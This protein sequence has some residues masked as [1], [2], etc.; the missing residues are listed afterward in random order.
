[1]N[2]DYL[3]DGSGDP[4]PKV[5]RLERLLGRL[6]HNRPAPEFPAPPVRSPRTRALFFRLTLAA[7]AVLLIAVAWQVAHRTETVHLEGS[8]RSG[9]TDHRPAPGPERPSG[10]QK[11]AWEVASL[12]GAPQVGPDRI[13]GT[14]RLPVGEWLE[15]DGASRARI[16]VGTIGQVQVEPNTRVR[17]VET[18]LTEHR[19]SLA[20]GTLHATIWAPPRLFFV[21]TPSAVAVDLG[22]AYTLKVDETGAGLVRVSA[23]W[24]A[25]EAGGRESFIPAGARC[26]TRPG[27]GPGTPCFEDAHEAL[28]AAL[29]KLDFEQESPA[30]RAAAL[31][32]VLTGARRRDAL[33]LW[34]LLSRVREAERAP[35][36]DRLSALVPPP[37]G[38]TRDDVL[39]GD[40]RALERWWDAL[41]L[42]DTAWW[43]LWKRA[44][45]SQIK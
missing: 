31:N 37:K 22:C 24:V 14:G 42:G 36:Y 19:L 16:A 34:H 6:R 4:D 32:A 40:R 12:E 39:S 33:T 18:R 27:I 38:V 15:T 7:A 9:E 44:W 21:E 23:G 26:A 29:V 10:P 1:M 25:F 30:A 28:Q 5:Q 41:G 45:P 11:A 17:L 3:W 8:N 2:E 20:R 13:A 43:R 35:V